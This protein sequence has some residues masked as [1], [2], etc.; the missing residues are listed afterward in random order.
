M[1]L[2]YI[3]TYVTI[4]PLVA[5]VKFSYKQSAPNTSTLSI[6]MALKKVLDLCVVLG[7]RSL[8]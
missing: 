5:P 1:T 4:R 2:P 3:T 8:T 6:L 7:S